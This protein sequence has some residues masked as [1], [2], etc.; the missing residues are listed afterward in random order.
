[1]KKVVLLAGVLAAGMAVAPV[2]ASAITPD[3]SD[4]PGVDATPSTKAAAKNV[5]FSVVTELNDQMKGFHALIKDEDPVVKAAF[6]DLYNALNTEIGGIKTDEEG[7]TDADFAAVSD[8][9]GK[10]QKA[11]AL[12]K[13]VET[14]ISKVAGQIDAYKNYLADVN[15]L[16]TLDYT[17]EA[18]Y[19]SY[20]CTYGTAVYD[21]QTPMDDANTAIALFKSTLNDLETLKTLDTA[22]TQTTL[23]GLAQDA[24]NKVEAAK[25]ALQDAQD[26]KADDLAQDDIE[27]AYAT[28]YTNIDSKY[29]TVKAATVDDHTT[30]DDASYP[31]YAPVFTAQGSNL[32]IIA[33]DIVNAKTSFTHDQ[34]AEK[35]ADILQRFSELHQS[36]T[37]FQTAFEKAMNDAAINDLVATLQKDIE[38][39]NAAKL[40]AEGYN[41]DR[42]EVYGGGGHVTTPQDPNITAIET[43]VGNAT[44]GLT[45]DVNTIKGWAP[46]VAVTNYP[47]WRAAIDYPVTGPH[48]QAVELIAK[49]DT[50]QTAADAASKTVVEHLVDAPT[51][52]VQAVV[53]AKIA[54]WKT[55]LEAFGYHDHATKDCEDCQKLYAEVVTDVIQKRINDLQTDI[56][57]A[58]AQT[59]QHGWEIYL[60]SEASKI[61]ADSYLDAQ[62]EVIKGK[63]AD[64]LKAL[65]AQN[66]KTEKAIHDIHHVAETAALDA[67]NFNDADKKVADAWAKTIE[68]G[69]VACTDFADYTAKV[70]ALYE[71]MEAARV[72]AYK[73]HKIA[74]LASLETNAK[75]AVVAN[76]YMKKVEANRAAKATLDTQLAKWQSELN[77]LVVGLDKARLYS[78][79][80][81]MGG[82]LDHYTVLTTTTTAQDALDGIK[83]AIESAYSAG[84]AASYVFPESTA[85]S[86][87]DGFAALRKGYEDLFAANKDAYEAL[88][89]ALT[90]FQGVYDLA[91]AAYDKAVAENAIYTTAIAGDNNDATDVKLAAIGTGIGIE[92][93]HILNGFKGGTLAT[94]NAVELGHLATLSS[95]LKTAEEALLGAAAF[96]LKNVEAYNAL[97]AQLA[98]V[99]E[100]K[101]T[102]DTEWAAVADE[103]YNV[104]GHKDNDAITALVGAIKPEVLAAS[105]LE[106]LNAGTIYDNKGDLQDAIAALSSSIE[107]ARAEI[108]KAVTFKAKSVE[109]YNALNEK[110]NDAAT[111]LKVLVDEAAVA[112]VYEVDGHMDA[113][114]IMTAIM[115]AQSN[116]FGPAQV[117]LEDALAKATVVANYDTLEEQVDALS[118]AVTALRTLLAEKVNFKAKNVEAAQELASLFE[119]LKDEVTTA[120]VGDTY[121]DDAEFLE[122]KRTELLGRIAVEAGYVTA[123]LAAGEV[124]TNYATSKEA[125]ETL[126]ADIKGFEGMIKDY[127][128]LLADNKEAKEAKLRAVGDVE[129]TLN[130]V[131]LNPEALYED[132]YETLYEKVEALYEQLETV[133]TEIVA[134]FNAKTAPAYEVP[135]ELRIKLA[136]LLGKKVELENLYAANLAGKTAL[137]AHAQSVLTAVNTTLDEAKCA[138]ADGCDEAIVDALSALVDEIAAVEVEVNTAFDAKKT[139]VEGEGT[140][141]GV[142]NNKLNDIEKALTNAKKQIA[143]F[144]DRVRTSQHAADNILDKMLDVNFWTTEAQVPGYEHFLVRQAHCSNPEVLYFNEIQDLVDELKSDV[145]F[146]NS[147][148]GGHTA[149]DNYNSYVKRL[150]DVKEKLEVLK[151][152]IQANEA[153]YALINDRYDELYNDA[154]AAYKFWH[155]YYAEQTLNDDWYTANKGWIQEW[156]GELEAG[157]YLV[158]LK[159]YFDDLYN[160]GNAAYEWT[161]DH[162][163]KELNDVATETFEKQDTDLAKDRNDLAHKEALNHW[164]TV[165]NTVDTAK[166]QVWDEYGQYDYWTDTTTWDPFA[167]NV[168]KGFNE[169]FEGEFGMIASLN[170]FKADIEAA[171]AE[172]VMEDAIN[173]DEHNTALGIHQQLNGVLGVLGMVMDEYA[174]LF[175]ESHHLTNGKKI[176][177]DQEYF[178]LGFF[179][180]ANDGSVENGQE[181]FKEVKVLVN[182]DIRLYDSR[183]Y[184][185]NDMGTDDWSDDE[186]LLDEK[187]RVVYDK[188]NNPGE[189]AE[190]T[191][192]TVGAKSN[193]L[194][195]NFHQNPMALERT[196]LKAGTAEVD[197]L[198]GSISVKGDNMAEAWTL[199]HTVSI[200]GID[201]LAPEVAEIQPGLYASNGK[202]IVR[203]DNPIDLTYTINSLIA[204]TDA[205]V[206]FS[207]A[208]RELNY[209]AGQIEFTLPEGTQSVELPEGF[210]TFR[211]GENTIARS[212][213]VVVTV[214]KGTTSIDELVAMGEKAQIFDL[215]GRRVKAES[216]ISGNTYVVNGEKVMVK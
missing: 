185:W 194:A 116:E 25:Q 83:T 184:V 93:A 3:V 48:A 47:I 73:H 84:T 201:V 17:A 26:A 55:A 159:N 105:F 183:S 88:T 28:L 128:K 19:P 215:Q 199:K 2:T 77:T 11:I 162:Q 152:A 149:F 27:A 46:I 139:A 117:A 208:D 118:D 210:F 167:A 198:P 141:Y 52:G 79:A 75:A 16:Q 50:D 175:A 78:D 104:E 132:D 146:D 22:A 156:D 129:A 140:Q 179:E 177:S 40:K 18:V 81:N 191:V 171:Y 143:D 31:I 58:L 63:L 150:L 134:A 214:G 113:T 155:Q 137:L 71:K 15:S 151:A 163:G 106:E 165:K 111:D 204:R 115:N 186:A 90:E 133:Q 203:V 189:I 32:S 4:V 174:D 216:L 190:V 123:D 61:M 188:V 66:E 10:Y 144:N 148:E 121:A 5:L 157:D 76:D 196:T 53:D 36:L 187:G 45:K 101:A 60:T 54:G 135:G 193:E 35:K 200:D 103:V 108:A 12:A 99:V 120:P 154:L 1:M 39:L 212:A 97:N 37:D 30:Y 13:E 182:D 41:N 126:L 72:E 29:N 114:A 107:N 164:Q 85:K 170:T 56:E 173:I 205:G 65:D 153:A 69:G 110:F 57:T 147:H 6:T 14:A 92:A 68:I 89:A 70:T 124:L 44:S 43:M 24:K 67:A 213:A 87:V 142:L 8:P 197:F 98:A 80:T 59:R 102:L 207:Y 112:D 206:E 125:Y 202:L 122:G 119:N 127:E 96:K 178:T 91:K 100:N 23:N 42:N 169:E 34:A 209:A 33:G 160:H 176:Y 145:L 181:M 161:V 172:G 211:T 38:D 130:G 21:V 94:D 86:A 7:F 195:F 20:S 51:T 166:F 138:V 136:E 49:V 168:M 64:H 131:V 180:K 74:D 95:D 192:L 158:M 62:F 82:T 109:A 9:A